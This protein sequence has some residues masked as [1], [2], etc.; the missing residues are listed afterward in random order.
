[1]M[2]QDRKRA[3]D[4]WTRAERL[5]LLALWVAVAAF[6]S[7]MLAAGWPRYWTYVAAET[8][9]QAWLE[10]VLLVLAAAIAGL[11]ALLAA[12]A[13]ELLADTGPNARRRIR[14][15]ERRQGLAWTV[16][17]AAFAWLALDERFAIHERLRD[18][19]FKQTGIRLLPWMEAGDWL[20]PI[21]A[22]CGLIA[23]WS[24]W[25]LLSARRSARAFFA[26]GVVVAAVAV[27][28]DTIDIRQLDKDAERLLQTIEEVLET[29]AMTAFVSAYLGALG[30][31]ICRA[32]GIGD[33]SDRAEKAR[34]ML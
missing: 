6:T 25:R 23:M 9:P 34:R 2:R 14:F 32:A 17:A 29:T 20:I 5:L 10:S 18:R 7:G 33:R 26:F 13:P 24:L 30:A 1:M 11:N 19:Y 21:Y 3:S 8:T 12:G 22:V 28:L 27:G 31:K 4:R 15:L 16:V